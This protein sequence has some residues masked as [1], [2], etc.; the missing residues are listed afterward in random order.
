MSGSTADETMTVAAGRALRGG[1]RCFVGIGL[2]STAA[3]LA[4]TTHAPDLV[5][6]YE[7]GTLGSKPGRLPASIGDG[8]LAETAD[9]VI[10]VPEVFNY[11]LQP[12]RIDIG[13]LGAA[14]LDR[15]GNINTTV[16]GD[17][18]TPKVRLPGAGG[19]PE[20]A[21]SCGEV[22]VVVRQS[23]QSFVER[24]DFVTSFGHGRG[25]GERAKL[26]LRGAGPTQ[27][28]TDL[29]IMR[30]DE[31]GELVLTA[32]HPGVTVDQVRAATGWELKV[33]DDL[34]V[35]EPPTDAELAALHTLQAAS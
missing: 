24:V 7:S 3:N 35:T 30:P 28:I 17:Y 26:G 11:W 27:V 10:S 21:A 4:R 34:A 22:F 15:F 8:I 13:F 1:K 14:Q 5:L 29:G 6:I 33:A 9:A 16:I 18:H 20:I 31:N 23:R 12:G 19:A 2:P 32:I 25:G